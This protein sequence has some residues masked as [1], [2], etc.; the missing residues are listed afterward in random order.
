[1]TALF[2]TH[3][4]ATWG[5]VGLIWTIQVVHYPL[6]AQVGREAFPVYHRRHTRSITWIVAPLMAVELISGLVLAMEDSSALL[7]WSLVLLGFNWLSTACIQI[8]LHNR[9]EKGFEPQAHARLVLS[10][11]G[12]T[13]AWSGRGILL[14]LVALR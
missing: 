6:F 4:V 13:L 9:L 10:N 14:V 11:W 8:P 5:L 3:L 1:M 12:R 7:R 2:L